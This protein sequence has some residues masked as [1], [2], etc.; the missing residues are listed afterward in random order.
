MVIE[1]KE[2]RSTQQAEVSQVDQYSMVI[3]TVQGTE[4]HRVTVPGVMLQEDDCEFVA[5][6]YW[7]RDCYIDEVYALLDE[8]GNEVHECTWEELLALR[9]VKIRDLTSADVISFIMETMQDKK[10]SEGWCLGFIFGFVTAC[11]DQFYGLACDSCG[12]HVGECQC[13]E[14]LVSALERL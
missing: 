2:S 5:G 8:D 7:G 3:D 1:I 4:Y 12:K 9:E 6:V 10:T 14:V 11:S 13:K